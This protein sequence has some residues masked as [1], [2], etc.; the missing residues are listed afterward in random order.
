MGLQHKRHI[1]IWSTTFVT[2][3]GLKFAHF[4]GQSQLYVQS[5]TWYKGDVSLQP[6]GLGLWAGRARASE[7]HSE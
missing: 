3:A 7:T 5:L 6:K 2:F 4:V 1:T